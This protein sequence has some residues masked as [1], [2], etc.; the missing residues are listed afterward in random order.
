MQAED[1]VKFQAMD[2]EDLID[3]ILNQNEEIRKLKEQLNRNSG[4]S[5]KPPSSDGYKKKK[6]PQS[7]RVKSE[8]KSG[9]QPDH[10]GSTLMLVENPDIIENYDIIK[11]DEC[12]Q[13]LSKVDA[14]ITV[15]QEIDIPPIKP[16]VTEHHLAS[17]VCPRCKKINK[18]G[19]KTLTQSVQYGAKIKALATYLHYEQLVPL[20]RTQGIFSDLFGLRISEGTLVNMHHEVSEQLTQPEIDIKRYL[21]KSLVNNFDETSLVVNNKT[22]WLHSVSNSMAT[23]Y[24][25]HKKRG[26]EAMDDMGILPNYT[27]IAQHDHWKCYFKYT[28]CKHAL[29]NAHHVRE[30]RGIFEN[31]QQDWANKMRLL[32]YIINDTVNDCKKTG[33]TELPQEQITEFSNSY[34]AILASAK[35]EVP[36]ATL[37]PNLKKRGRLKQHPSKNLLDRLTQ[38]KQETLLFM[39]DFRVAF[40]NNQAERDVR[41]MKLRQKISGCFRSEQGAQRFCR[42]RGYISTARKQNINILS[43]IELAARGQPPNLFT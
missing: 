8:K 31:Y 11:C 10:N 17:K 21:M 42:I 16:K 33:V 41:M 2:K 39:Y 27:G 15:R 22:Q 36:V 35:N 3:I 23:L 32:L 24:L 1:R 9:G 37:V 12:K 14:E 28:S 6:K 18:A 30:L 43:A 13:D 5:S 40:S 25:I 4:N 20:Q 34:D 7:E 38:F 29:C 26:T 19:P